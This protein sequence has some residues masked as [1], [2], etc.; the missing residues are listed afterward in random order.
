[1]I[2]RYEPG[3]RKSRVV[4]YNGVAYLGVQS[5]HLMDWI[6]PEAFGLI[7]PAFA[8]ELVWGEAF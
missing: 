2:Q 5:R 4:T 1:M 7:C 6:Q 8:Y 3:K